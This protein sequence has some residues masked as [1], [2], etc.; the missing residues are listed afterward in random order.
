[1]DAANMLPGKCTTV[2]ER[3]RQRELCLTEWAGRIDLQS[4]CSAAAAA[5]TPDTTVF[6]CVSE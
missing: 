5:C 3:E 4:I 1:M 2:R 6:V